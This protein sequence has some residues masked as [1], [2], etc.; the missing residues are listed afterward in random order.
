MTKRIYISG[1]SGSGVSTLGAALA[2]KLQV[3]HVDVDDYYWYPTD[4]PFVHSRP[5]ADRVNLLSSRLAE[6]S[7]IVSGAMDGWGDEVFQ[8]AELVVFIETPTAV[9]IERLKARELRSY[10]DRVLPGGDMHANHQAFVAWAQSYEAGTE[11][12]RSRP[13]HERWLSQLDVPCIRV[14]GELPTADLLKQVLVEIKD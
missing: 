13:R 11:G 1:A 8:R 10:G 3:P 2:V 5:P 9:R 14:S 7:W 6:G 12:G 4:P